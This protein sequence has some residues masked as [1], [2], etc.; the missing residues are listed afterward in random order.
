[1]IS[2]FSTIKIA[3][4]A[5]SGIKSAGQIFSKLLLDH[6]YSLVDYSEYPSLVR[7][8]HNTYQITFSA[9]K[10]FSVHHSVDFFFSVYP[11]H[12][13]QHQGEFTKNT[14]LF[15]EEDFSNIKSKAT[16]VNLPLRELSL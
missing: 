11:G 2:K 4:P 3:G 14:L 5:G 9:S 15:S 12:W 8:G 13:Q 7:G 16:L 1:M 6:N 10:V